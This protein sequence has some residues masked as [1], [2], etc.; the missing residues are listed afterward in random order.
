MEKQ[1]GDRSAGGAATGQR[2]EIGVAAAHIYS[3]K[4]KYAAPGC[5]GQEEKIGV[6]LPAQLGDAQVQTICRQK[7]ALPGKAQDRAQVC[8][9]QLFHASS[10]FVFQ[11]PL[12]SP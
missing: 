9:Y 2:T 10:S 6:F 12:L 4:T 7:A 11:L 1:S 8:L 5:P 3:G